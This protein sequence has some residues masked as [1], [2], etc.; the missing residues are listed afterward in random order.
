MWEE[1]EIILSVKKGGR[2]PE[3]RLETPSK[4]Q[5]EVLSAFATTL[6]R[7][8][9]YGIPPAKAL[10]GKDSR[11]A[12]PFIPEDPDYRVEHIFQGV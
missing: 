5:S 8:G 7:V 12:A 10:R 9:F 2:T 11:S 1:S 4:A 3:G 6:M